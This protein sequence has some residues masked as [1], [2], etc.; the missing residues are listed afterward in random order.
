MSHTQTKSA[1]YGQGVVIFIYLAILTALEYFVAITF[2]AVSILVVVAVIKAALVMYY[3]M[4]IYKL[5][6]DSEGDEHSYDYKTGTNRIGLWLFLLSDGFVF[7]GLLVTRINLLGLTRPHLNQTLGL[8]VTAVL[9]VS[10]FFMNRGE[11]AMAHGDKKGFMNNTLIT[12][13]LG[14]GFLLGVVMVEWRLAAEEGLTASFGNPAVGPMG[15]VFYIMTGM[16]AFHV[17]T[18][19]IF[20][21]I[22]WNNARKDVYSAEKHWGVEAA[23][24]YWHFVDLVWIFFYPA[25]YLIG[26]LV[27]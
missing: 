4:H 14:L 27:N 1:A 18:G 9:L 11:T 2:N 21:L 8:A 5:N 24:V 13:V 3:Y 7:A 6:E 17:L 10:S 20:L 19:L 15:G 26:K 12:F 23:A 16:H 25:L 22:V